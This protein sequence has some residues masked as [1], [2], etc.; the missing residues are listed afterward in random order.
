MRN[1]LQPWSLPTRSLLQHLVPQVMKSN[2]WLR[3]IRRYASATWGSG[4]EI[5]HFIFSYKIGYLSLFYVIIIHNTPYLYVIHMNLV[6]AFLKMT[7]VF[8]LS[9]LFVLITSTK[10]TILNYSYFFLI[11][12][13]IHNNH[14]K[15]RKLSNPLRRMYKLLWITTFSILRYL[16]CLYIYVL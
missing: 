1:K 11:I 5:C 14:I 13:V 7:Q 2:V 4:F 16:C 3:T 9:W 6:N 15:F 10:R 12:S 8:F